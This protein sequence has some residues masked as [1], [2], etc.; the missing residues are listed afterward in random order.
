MPSGWTRWILEQYEF[1][2]EVVFPQTLDAG[3]LNAKYDVLVFVDGAIPMRD[4]AARRRRRL[5]RTAGGRVDPG[6]VPRHGWP[7]HRREDGAGAE[8][9]RGERRHDPHDRI[10][11][12]ARPS[13][14]APDQERA[15]RT[16][17]RRASG[18]CRARSSTCRDRSSKRAID[19][20]DPL[21][22]GMERHARR[23][24]RR[25]PGV[26]AAAGGGA[27]GREAGRVVRHRVAAAQRLGVGPAVSRSGRARSSMRRSG[28]GRRALRQRGLWRGQPHGTFKLF[29]NGIYSGS[30]GAAPGA[31]RS[32]DQPQR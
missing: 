27:E 30:A 25:E 15:R 7:R 13:P 31:A 10:V 18:R 16:R 12:G 23:V 3:N 26:P 28:R 24:L 20:T 14:R 5:R 22:Y 1:P 11:D 6:G 8:E 9:V 29:F 32:T 17:D 21:A 2:F 4:A 19:N